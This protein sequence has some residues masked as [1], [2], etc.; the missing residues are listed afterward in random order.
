MAQSVF[1]SPVIILYMSF[2]L[3]CRPI[4]VTLVITTRNHRCCQIN[5][6]ETLSAYSTSVQLHEDDYGKVHECVMPVTCSCVWWKSSCAALRSC[7]SLACRPWNL[8]SDRDL[9]SFP[10]PDTNLAIPFLQRGSQAKAEGQSLCPSLGP[11]VYQ[12]QSNFM[13]FNGRLVMFHINKSRAPVCC[14]CG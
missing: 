7:Y 10:K 12:I 8:P 13:G 1:A 6:Q 4:I 14:S 2:S 5:W 11:Q 3:N 9:I